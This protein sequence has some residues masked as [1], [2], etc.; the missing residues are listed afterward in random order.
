MTAKSPYQP[1]QQLRAEDTPNDSASQLPFG[2]SVAVI[3]RGS[4][5]NTVRAK[6]G[7][8]NA[9][10]TDTYG[11]ESRVVVK[12][13][14]LIYHM[15]VPITLTFMQWERGVEIKVHHFLATHVLY[16]RTSMYLDQDRKVN[17]QVAYLPDLQGVT[18]LGLLAVVVM[19]VILLSLPSPI[20]DH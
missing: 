13:H 16:N 20:E 4:G 17:C 18:D 6:C 14:I 9:G 10:R 15:P 5:C 12:T 1:H 3:G 19:R 11:C 8:K 7:A 2:Q